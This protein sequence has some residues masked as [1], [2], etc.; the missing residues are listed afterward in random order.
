MDDIIRNIPYITWNYHID[1]MNDFKSKGRLT[2]KKYIIPNILHIQ[3]Y[4]SQMNGDDRTMCEKNTLYHIDIHIEQLY[5][6]Q[7]NWDDGTMSG[8]NT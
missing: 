7:M 5:D 1:Q 2:K 4:D 3:L 8:K 6:S